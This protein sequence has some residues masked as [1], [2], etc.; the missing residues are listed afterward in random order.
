M[1]EKLRIA[2]EHPPQELRRRD[3]WEVREAGGTGLQLPENDLNGG[4]DH[5]QR[6]AAARV[7]SAGIQWSPAAHVDL[8]IRVSQGR[9]MVDRMR[10]LWTSQ[11]QYHPRAEAFTSY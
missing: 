2:G 6:L 5:L 8:P 4:Q 10:I 3:Q 1:R 9:G 11:L 7:H